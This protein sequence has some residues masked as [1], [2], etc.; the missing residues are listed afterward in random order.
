[1]GQQNGPSCLIRKAKVVSHYAADQAPFPRGYR[2]D[3]VSGVEQL[4]RTRFADDARQDPSAT[5]ARNDPELQESHTELRFLR[6]DTDIAEARDVTTQA[7][8]R[9]V[10]G[11]D[12]RHAQAIERAQH[13]VDIVT[14][15]VMS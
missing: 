2:V 9:A 12:H 7:N 11:R 10:D 6:R 14:V 15:P 8:R 13:A 4:G 3:H 5:V 1:M